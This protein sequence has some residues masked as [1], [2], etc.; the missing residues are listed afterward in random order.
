VKDE[1]LPKNFP[2]WTAVGV[3]QLAL[4]ELRFEIRAIA[5]VG[6]GKGR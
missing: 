5:V 2:A 4:P 3:T 6:C 1:F